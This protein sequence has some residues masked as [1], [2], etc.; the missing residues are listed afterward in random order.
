MAHFSATDAALEGFR[1]ARRNPKA[2]VVWALLAL[3]FNFAIISVMIAIAGPA[4]TE[5]NEL[6][7]AGPA[8]ANSARTLE[9]AGPVMAGYLA[10]I[11]LAF[12]YLAVFSGA[13]FRG[14][15]QPQDRAPG[16]LKL[17]GD[18]LRLLATSIVVCVISMV[19]IF[20]ISLILTILVGVIATAASGGGE[21]NLAVMIPGILLLYVAII[22]AAL[23]IYVKFSF[24]GPMTFVRKKILIFQSWGATNGRFWPLFG[25]YLLAIVLGVIVTL[26]GAVIGLAA[27]MALGGS[28]TALTSPNMS[29]LAAY[30][31]PGMIAYLIV[32]S[33]VSGLTF[34][35]YQ[36]PAMTAYQA[37]H[38]AGGDVSGTF[39]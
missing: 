34:A 25:C 21:P 19:A 24:A 7:R 38:G 29:S 30:F 12:I 13:I 9:L 23:A 37:I 5:L 35:I 8:A 11:P 26:L 22:F 18:E 27:M 4:L 3:V 16:F 28:I 6:N 1:L 10:M 17:G 33:I 39:D 14:L 36:A 31:T 15:V 32:N 20:L 2:V